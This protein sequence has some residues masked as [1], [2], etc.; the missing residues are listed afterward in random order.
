MGL[1]QEYTAMKLT[2]DQ[3]SLLREFMLA[4]NTENWGSWP[5]PQFWPYFGLSYTLSQYDFHG[6]HTVATLDLWVELPDGRKT[7]RLAVG[8]CC[9][10]LPFSATKIG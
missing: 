7:C 8:P 6:V 10:S 4:R 1:R 5:G 9:H 2:A 3:L